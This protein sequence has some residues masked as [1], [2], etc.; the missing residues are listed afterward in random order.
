MCWR[1]DRFSRSLRNLL[2]AIDQRSGYGVSFHSLNEGIDTHSVTGRFTL[3]I[4]GA[5]AEMERSKF[6]SV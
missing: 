5:I 6:S 1:L 4:L 2:F 3:A